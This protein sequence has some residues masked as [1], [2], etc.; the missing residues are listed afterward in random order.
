MEGLPD[1]RKIHAEIIMGHLISCQVHTIHRWHPKSWPDQQKE[2]GEM[3]G[4]TAWSIAQRSQ[5]VYW[6]EFWIMGLFC[7]GLNTLN[8]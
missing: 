7:M 6:V 2:D 4:K 5:E 1:H 3:R 8:N